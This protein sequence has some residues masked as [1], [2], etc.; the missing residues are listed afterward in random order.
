MRPHRSSD[1]PPCVCLDCV[2]RNVLL[3]RLV[4][5]ARSVWRWASFRSRRSKPYRNR[6]YRRRP[7][8]SFGNLSLIA[9][10]QF[11]LLEFGAHAL[12]FLGDGIRLAIAGQPMARGAMFQQFRQVE[13]AI[14]IMIRMRL[15]DHP[16]RSHGAARRSG[17]STSTAPRRIAREVALAG[18]AHRAVG[19]RTVQRPRAWIASRPTDPHLALLDQ[20]PGSHEKRGFPH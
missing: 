9:C 5:V 18:I 2:W 8:S 17:R 7:T 10:G 14:Q 16:I 4:N 1:M 20:R 11:I 13:G 19:I 3:T 12:R 6:R 15:E